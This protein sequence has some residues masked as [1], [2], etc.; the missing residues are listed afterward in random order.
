MN[1][2]QA[3]IAVQGLR[4]RFGATDAVNGVDFTVPQ[5]CVCGFLGRNGAGKTTTI[6]M[7]LGM[8]HADGGEGRIF[9]ES[10]GTEAASVRIRQRTGFVAEVKEFYP[11]MTVRQMIDFNR[12][13]YP[14]WQDRWEQRCLKDYELPLGQK[15][16]KLSKGTRSKLALLLAF[17]RGADLL[18]LDEPSEGL[19][20]VAVEIFL[21][22]LV[23]LA[24]E[25]RTVFFSSHQLDEVEQ[26]CE[27]VC[28]ID[29]GQTVLETDLDDLKTRIQK[30]SLTFPDAVPED[31]FDEMA[32]KRLKV[33]GRSASLLIDGDAEAL[34]A[35]A[36]A[37][38]ATSI[39]FAPVN[40]KEIFLETVGGR[41]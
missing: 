27:R 40:L 12:A 26:V 11:F 28:L 31:I 33:R 9:G 14:Q 6:K 2:D 41:L 3:I 37:A 4:K 19:D 8:M 24:A 16:G 23:A 36:R 17:S 29:H 13:F 1:S 25:G 39:E 32:V 38:G 30:V 18:I 10:I 22:H 21:E 20:P 5:G 7:L 35:Q 34:E 15:T